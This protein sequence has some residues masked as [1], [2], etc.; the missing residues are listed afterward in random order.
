MIL[1]LLESNRSD[2]SEATTFAFK[3]ATI[4]KIDSNNVS[5]SKF[6]PDLCNCAKKETT[7][8][9]APPQR[10]YKQVQVSG[11]SYTPVSYSGHV[12]IDNFPVDAFITKNPAMVLIC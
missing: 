6:K 5:K 10:P 3:S 12:E 2:V 8:A 11:R 4:C 7:E 1:T 9:T